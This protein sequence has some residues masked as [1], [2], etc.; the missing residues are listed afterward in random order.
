MYTNIGDKMK[1]YII[2]IVLFFSLLI[3]FTSCKNQNLRKKSEKQEKRAIFISYIELKKYIK[4]NDVI[5]SKKN[6]DQMIDNIDNFNFN[7]IILQVRSFS[8]AIYES[9]IFPWSLTV[10]KEEGLSPGF[11]ILNYFVTNSHEK[12][13]E[14]HAWINP[15]RIRNTNNT[16]DISTKNIAYS[17]LNTDDV[18]ISDAGIYYNPSSQKVQDLI[19]DGVEEIVEKYDVDG[20]HFDDYFY[21]NNKEIDLNNFNEYKK[22]YKDISIDEYRLMVVNNLI[23]RV[24]NITKKNNVLFGVSPDGNIENNYNKNYADIYKWGSSNKYV[25][26]I[27]PQIYYGFNNE[28]KPFY[29]TLKTWEEVVKE[30]DVEI[31]PALAFY[32][33]DQIDN[34]AK[35]GSDEWIKYDDI[36]MRQVILSRNIKNYQGFSIFRYDSIFSEEEKSQTVMNEVKNLKKIISK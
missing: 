30:S 19:V 2:I 8:D 16:S 28:I 10:S 4:G 6:I 29:T 11:D 1:K 5:T 14:L 24:H 31:L 3:I 21:P 33:V 20:I 36:I 17:L 27:M 35:G 25:D 12:G 22:K 26:Y 18:S 13:I 23:E 15:Y 32:K 7:M 34:Y 9:N